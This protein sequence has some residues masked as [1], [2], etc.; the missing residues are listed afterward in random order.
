[1]EAGYLGSPTQTL[2]MGDRITWRSQ[3]GRWASRV[4]EREDADI[5]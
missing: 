3:G 5:S 4:M 1:L 2:N